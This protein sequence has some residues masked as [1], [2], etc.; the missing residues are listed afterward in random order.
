ME[1]WSLVLLGM[2]VG[3][4]HAFE[5]DHLAAMSTLFSDKSSRSSFIKRGAVWGFGHT[6]S[7]LVI[8]G[9]V[10]FFN[11]TITPLIEATLELCVG[12]M[13]LVLGINL[14]ITIKRRSIHAHVHNHDN[15]QKHLHIHSHEVDQSHNMHAVGRV[16]K[17][18]SNK[19]LFRPFGI[20]LVHGAAGSG[21]LLIAIALTADSLATALWSILIFGVGSIVGMAALSLAVSYPL[22]IVSN[23]S[24]RFQ[25]LAMTSVSVVAMIIGGNLI[26]V[27]WLAI[28]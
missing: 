14:F 19:P 15:G 9:V 16:K 21:A 3:M 23:I 24:D 17:A 5:A 20:G 18:P 6:F 28:R 13:V 10:L 11:L 1:G 25:R 22:N 2:L 8:C 26:M 4:Q 27:S 12:L 7:L